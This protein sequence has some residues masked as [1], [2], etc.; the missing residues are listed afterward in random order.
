MDESSLNIEN[1]KV[2]ANLISG[3]RT[4]LLTIYGIQDDTFRVT[5]EDVNRPRF[6]IPDALAGEPSLAQ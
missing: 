5:I 4:L 6:A 1:N 2:S 3:N